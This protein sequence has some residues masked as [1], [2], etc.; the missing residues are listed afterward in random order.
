MEP[1]MSDLRLTQP[2][3]FPV[4]KCHPESP[5]NKSII[6]FL[7]RS[8]HGPFREVVA[9]PDLI[10]DPCIFFHPTLCQA[11][12][13]WGEPVGGQWEV[14]KDKHGNEGDSNGHSTFDV[15]KPTP[16]FVTES[17]L[18]SIENAGSN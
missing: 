6:V 15:E 5:P 7:S 9:I 18:H 4:S 14:G 16:R 11:P 3:H 2:P 8:E 13:R 17:P 12:L 1:H 10:N